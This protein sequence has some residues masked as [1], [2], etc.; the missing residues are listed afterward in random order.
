MKMGDPLDEATDIGTII[1]KQQYD[2]V[3]SYIEYGEKTPG[4]QGQ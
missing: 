2:K 1:S 4:R 3:I